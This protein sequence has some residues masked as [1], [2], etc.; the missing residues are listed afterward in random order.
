M[1]W[2]TIALAAVG[3]DQPRHDLQQRR[4]ARAVAP[5]QRQP[6]ALADGELDVGEQRLPAE[7]ER[8]V[9]E[10]EKGRRGGHVGRGR[11][12]RQRTFARRHAR[13]LIGASDSLVR[14]VGDRLSSQSRNGLPR[15][16]ARHLP[17]GRW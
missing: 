12:V 6:L 9:S 4:F 7:A 8:D 14:G 10:R 2:R 15:R 1:P 5:D 16:Q 11:R 17:Q 13:D 3:L